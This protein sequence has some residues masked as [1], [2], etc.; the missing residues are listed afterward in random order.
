MQ[1]ETC[2][3]LLE[4]K[5]GLAPVVEPKYVLDVA[6][7]TGI[8]AVEYAERHP[9]SVVVGSDLSCIQQAS[10]PPNCSFVQHDVERD[11]W[12]LFGRMF[13]YIHMRFVITC[14]DD[15]QVV[16][17][18]CFDN[19]RPDGYIEIFDV[20]HD[21]ID[22]DGSARG[23]TFERWT[24]EIRRAA[25][26]RGRDLTEA[27]QYPAW[28]RDAG[29]VDV[30]EELIPVPCGPWAKD[31]RLKAIGRRWM[32]TWTGVLSALSKLFASEGLVQDGIEGLQEEAMRECLDPNIHLGF[33]LRVTYGRK[34]A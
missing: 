9:E 22:F 10:R 16:L 18:R 3:L 12:E 21:P 5:L 23:S 32:V 30:T 6:T 4:G 27:K 25:L 29:F 17:R 15:T 34:P 7:G 28:C 2:L 14:F 19:L 13:D 11:S 31:P 20:S 1:H 8:W 24:H 33:V 26:K